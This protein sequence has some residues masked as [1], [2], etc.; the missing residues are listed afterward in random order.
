M[1][2]IVVTATEA[3]S[4][5]L[6]RSM[7]STE[8]RDSGEGIRCFYHDNRPV[9]SRRFGDSRVATYV[10]F[11][12]CTGIILRTHES[13]AIPFHMCYH[14]ASVR[15]AK[16]STS[17]R[18]AVRLGQSLDLTVPSFLKLYDGVVSYHLTSMPCLLSPVHH[19]LDVFP[20][21]RR[22]YTAHAHPTLSGSQRDSSTTPPV[23]AATASHCPFPRS[24]STTPLPLP[25]HL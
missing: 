3:E 6:S 4:R 7:Y 8:L 2:L 20:C 22:P 10:V 13:M 1:T 21:F 17:T 14:H 5:H 11:C 16:R 9:E 15:S 19:P 24:L 12:L 23:H 25:Q 18:K